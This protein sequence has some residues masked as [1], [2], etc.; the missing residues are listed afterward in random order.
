MARDARAG[1]RFGLAAV[2]LFLLLLLPSVQAP[3]PPGIG[4]EPPPLVL[5][6]RVDAQTVS[7]VGAGLGQFVEVAEGCHV[8]CVTESYC[9]VFV[10]DL[11]TLDYVPFRMT[12]LDLVGTWRTAR[13][14]DYGGYLCIGIANLRSPSLFLVPE[15]GE[16]A[17][18]TANAQDDDG[19]YC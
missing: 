19:L 12:Y 10:R 16:G 14:V 11:Q 7:C 3:P 18:G 9:A 1:A 6:T 2:F 17:L 4:G 13:S 8:L 5:W 15:P